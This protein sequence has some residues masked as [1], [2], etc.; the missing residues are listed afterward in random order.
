M[1]SKSLKE[2]LVKYAAIYCI[3]E[4]IL[5]YYI[6]ERILDILLNT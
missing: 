2:S 4:T 1:I 5:D 6:L 3:F